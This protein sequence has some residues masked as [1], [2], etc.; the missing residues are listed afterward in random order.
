MVALI[1]TAW[2]WLPRRH[3]ASFYRTH[4]ILAFIAALGTIAHGY[5]ATISRGKVPGSLP[6]AGIWL[7]DIALR[8]IFMNGV[9]HELPAATPL[10]QT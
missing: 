9:P 3:Y 2:R 1:L 5:G 10:M 6:G 4:V 7:L 8:M